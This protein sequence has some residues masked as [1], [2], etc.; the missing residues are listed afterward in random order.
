MAAKAA[1][2][3]FDIDDTLYLERD[4]VRSGFAA[5]GRAVGCA[6][7]GDAC[8]DLFLGG[9]RGNTF[10]LARRDFARAGLPP[11]P[12]LVAIYRAHRPD[13]ALCADARRFIENQT[14][15]TGLISDG[16]LVAQRAKFRALNLHV[17]ID[18]PLFTAEIGAPKPSPRAFEIVAAA[19]GAPDVRAVYVADNPAKDFEG[20]LRAGAEAVRIRRAGS[21][22]ENADTPPGV[23]EITSFDDLAI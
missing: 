15:P 6:A 16:S 20:A 19:L 13:I 4:Y 2:Y 11:T 5:V 1:S 12:D 3:I 14:R 7:F 21:L 18:Y 22:H 17:W 8:W 10:D 9:A 23:R